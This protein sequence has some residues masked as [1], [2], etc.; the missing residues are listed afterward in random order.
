MLL[1]TMASELGE[2]C[3]FLP[4]KVT[5]LVAPQLLERITLGAAGPPTTTAPAAG[6]GVAQL[7]QAIERAGMSAAEQS[8]LAADMGRLRE[9]C[10]GARSSGIA[11]LLDA[12]Q[13]HRQPAIHVA[14]PGSKC[15]PP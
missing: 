15:D 5:S 8:E 12:E 4:L 13:S 2:A 6:D 14:A 9:L 3:S 1:Q 10:D 7:S 11:L